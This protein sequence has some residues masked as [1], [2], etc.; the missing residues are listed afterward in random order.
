[1]WYQHLYI[2][3]YGIASNHPL[4]DSYYDTSDADIVSFKL[5]D[6][7]EWS[8]FVFLYGSKIFVRYKTDSSKVYLEIYFS[9][10]ELVEW[11]IQERYLGFDIK[12]EDMLNAIENGEHDFESGYS[13]WICNKA[14]FGHGNSPFYSLPF[15]AP[16]DVFFNASFDKPQNETIFAFYMLPF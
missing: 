14:Y 12:H 1:M 16:N 9:T 8:V 4:Y 11:Q 10:K 6:S 3:F 15:T 2:P 5:P 7:L 13:V